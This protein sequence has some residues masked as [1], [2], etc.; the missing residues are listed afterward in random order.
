M[1]KLALTVMV[2]GSTAALAACSSNET[3]TEDV[4]YSS[5][6]YAEERT[7]GTAQEAPVVRSAAP[8]FQETQMK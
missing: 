4:T 5:G 7:V 8:V 2:L 1:K 3:Y 6:P